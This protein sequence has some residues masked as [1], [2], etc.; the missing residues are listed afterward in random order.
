MRIFHLLIKRPLTHPVM[1]G[2]GKAFE[3]TK[4]PLLKEEAGSNTACDL[5]SS[6]I[7]FCRNWH[8]DLSACQPVRQLVDRR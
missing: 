8:L 2:L 4:R 5:S 7:H 1:R 3:K 6:R